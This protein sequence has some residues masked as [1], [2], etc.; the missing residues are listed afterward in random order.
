M[1]NPY[2]SL[3]RPLTI[4]GMTVKNRFA[5]APLS[6]PSLYGPYG[7]F[8]A[9]GLA[10]YEARAR[11]GF[12][13]LFTGA[14]HPYTETDPI[15]PYD[16]K[17]PMKA[18]KAFMR[19]AI[20]MNERLDAYGSKMMPQLSLGY[21][22]NT[23]GCA[24]PSEIP[25]YADPSRMAPALTKDQIR[26][27]IDRIIETAAFFQKCGFPGVEMH[28]MHW[29]YLLDQFAMTLTN[30]RT[31]EYGGALENRL[32]VAKELVEGIKA[33]C[34]GK[35]AVSM[36]LA[37][38]TYMKGF[39]QA[40]LHGEDEAGRTLEEGVEIAKKLESYGYDCLSVDFGQYDSFYY[41]APPCYMEKG[42]ILSL[43]EQAKAA[44]GIPVLCSGRMND[45]ALAAQAV[46]EG[47][48]DGVVLGRQALADPAFPQKLAKNCPQDIRP[49]IGCNQGCIGAL[50]TGRRVGCAVNPLAGREFSHPTLPALEK[51]R[52]LVV[53]GGV[54]G[55]EAAQTA[56]RR[57]HTVTL[58]EGSDHLG[59]N[60][61]PAGAHDFKA[62]MNELN[63]WYQRQLEKQGVTVRL[64]TRADG[65]SIKKAAPDA[66][67]LAVG[68]DPVTPPVPG[69][70][71]AIDCVSALTGTPVGQNVVVVGGGLVGCET[72]LGYANEGKTVTIVEALPDI[73]SAG[74]KVPVMNDQMLRD[75]LDE[76][77][78]TIRTGCR[79]SAV[80]DG[81]VTV[82]T[83][84]GEETFP[85]DSVVLSVG[86]RSR[87]TL[88]GELADSG[89]EVYQIGDGNQ[90]GNVM[91]AIDAAHT[92]ARSL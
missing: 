65:E 13:L 8:N 33:A 36:R 34:G 55:M 39:N 43:A 19:S 20:E 49:C 67:I 90:V 17:P 78:V 76:A 11:G 47:T 79:L 86:F 50:M 25:Y 3:F 28:A 74:I 30:H 91:T 92:V 88:A 45:P 77:G 18:P 89:L 84:R 73:L 53:G 9:D 38:K 15:H 29:G 60:L 54:A 10:F 63:A 87:K 71:K 44:V 4:G 62:E 68:A 58:Y 6:L 72:A 37:L 46:T 40:S 24:A 32:R 64:N 23:L 48:I 2:S 31:D 83:E 61:L 81:T 35:F 27:K 80:G 42:R 66:V 16:T 5:V 59:G 70:E 69:I 51:K 85:A 75:L 1:S 12:G 26:Y 14:F 56:A 82:T 21:G 7:E 52:V 22:R 41:A 57:G